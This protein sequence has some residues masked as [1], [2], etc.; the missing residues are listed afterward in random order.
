[1]SRETV[2][3]VQTFNPGRGDKLSADKP[4]PCKSADAARRMAERLALTR[5]GVIALSSSADSGL[6]DYDDEPIVI[7]KA[8]RLPAPFDE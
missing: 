6:G 7:F 5:V 4:I 8:G 3:V 1:M 2:F